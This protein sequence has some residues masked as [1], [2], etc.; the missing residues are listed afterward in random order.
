MPSR[1]SLNPY[2]LVFGARDAYAMRFYFI[3][4]P[5]DDKVVFQLAM[6]AWNNGLVMAPNQDMVIVPVAF[7]HSSASAIRGTTL[8]VA[9][10]SASSGRDIF[11]HATVNTVDVLTMIKSASSL[12][13]KVFS[14]II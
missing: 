3:M 14:H 5:P 13:V 8:E 2:F 12:L 10:D 1:R 6:S 9:I 4:S 11:Y 7:Q